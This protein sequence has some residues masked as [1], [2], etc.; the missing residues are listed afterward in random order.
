MGHVR[1]I[2]WQFDSPIG[3]AVDSSG[4]VFVADFY[5]KRI[6]KFTN[7]GAFLAKWGEL[8]SLDGQFGSPI[9]VAELFRKCIC[10]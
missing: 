4:N 10:I 6:Q 9:G 5:N 7:N 3:V 1:F 8:G 2:S